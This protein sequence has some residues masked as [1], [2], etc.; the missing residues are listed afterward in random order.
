MMHLNNLCFLS[1]YGNFIFCCKSRSK[2]RVYVTMY[3]LCLLNKLKHK[4]DKLT[5]FKINVM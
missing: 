2:I 4:L 5:N 1:K 3:R